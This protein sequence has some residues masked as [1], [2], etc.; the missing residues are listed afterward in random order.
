[1][2][3]LPQILNLPVAAA[4]NTV[5]SAPTAGFGL[6]GIDY[7]VILSFL[8]GITVVGLMFTKKASKGTSEFM[9]GG[10][11]MPWWLA[12][13]A[14]IAGN[15]DASA[16]L[17]QSG[18]IRNDGIQGNWFYWRQVIDT[19]VGAFLFNRLFRRARLKTPVE[20]YSL[21]Y[22]GK[23]QV[24][25]RIWTGTYLGFLL[26][27]L[28]C[29]SS[30][31]AMNKIVRIMFPE[32]PPELLGIPTPMVVS[33]CA[34]GLAMLFSASSGVYGVVWTDL[35]EFAIA[36][37]C[38]FV[39]VFYVYADPVIGWGSGLRERLVDGGYER[40]LQWMPT[41]LPIL[42]VLFLVLP[43]FSLGNM[44]YSVNRML[45]V[46]DEREVIYSSF[47]NMFNLYVLRSWPWFICGLASLF[48]LTDAQIMSTFGTNVADP[49]LIYPALI[50]RYMPAGLMGLMVAGF[51]AAFLGHKTS[52]LHAAS[53][54]I[55]NDI[56]RPHLAP[57]ASEKHYVLATRLVIVSITILAI[58]LSNYITSLLGILMFIFAI[59]SAAGLIVFGR[60]IWWRIN[61]WSDITGLVGGAA[62]TFFYQ[63]STVGKELVDA[64]ILK[65]TLFRHPEA[66]GQLTGFLGTLGEQVALLKAA[67]FVPGD[68]LFCTRVL[69]IVGT[70]SLLAITVMFL[71]PPEPRDKLVEFYKRVR[72][73]GFWG[74][75]KELCPGYEPP[76]P[77]SKVLR[78]ILAGLVFFFVGI[79]TF[80]CLFLAMWLQAAILLTIFVTWGFFLM[81]AIDREFAPREDEAQAETRND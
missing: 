7:V 36:M 72:P 34:M 54:I 32:L 14:M 60:W 74:P 73:H 15:M 1:M 50:V 47:W 61:I 6:H 70:T 12:G 13:T 18:K 27:T 49:E 56:Y 9:V 53:S 39:L 26:G 16:P 10:R 20:F 35:I 2:Q 42:L 28:G 11:K 66:A 21:R 5:D 22:A 8:I 76:E 25:A 23:G 24:F 33:S 64:I 68:L 57:A 29:A 45:A 78:F 55:V 77:F 67:G 44:N 41:D 46:K 37:L 30:L 52:S 62:A 71:T 81:R 79:F 80:A 38:S 40:L 17:Q 3:L 63:F 58:V 48:L 31:V 75:I 43:I 51:L 69:L 4:V 65:Y 59:H 19:C